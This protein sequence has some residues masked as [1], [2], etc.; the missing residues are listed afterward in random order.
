[1]NKNRKKKKKKRK[2]RT[3]F[4]K[5]APKP[6]TLP[7]ITT[8]YQCCIEEDGTPIAGCGYKFTKPNPK[9]VLCPRCGNLYVK[10]LGYHKEN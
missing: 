6:M 2:N 10:W 8:F 4:G 1:M 5:A 7:G 3:R 9:N